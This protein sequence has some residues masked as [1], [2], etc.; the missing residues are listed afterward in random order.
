M[1]LI[2]VCRD[3]VGKGFCFYQRILITRDAV[4]V[5]MDNYAVVFCVI[6]FL[7]HFINKFILKPV[8]NAGIKFNIGIH[9]FHSVVICDKSGLPGFIITGDFCVCRRN[10]A[11]CAV[12]KSNFAR[13]IIKRAYVS[14][15]CAV[16]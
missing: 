15:A 11:V 16:E 14:R 2:F 1:H 12:A 7:V 3:I 10:V 4:T 9:C 6:A 5:R 8:N 13:F